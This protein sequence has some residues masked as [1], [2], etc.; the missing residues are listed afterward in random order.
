MGLDIGYFFA[1][2]YVLFGL[3]LLHRDF[4]FLVRVPPSFPLFCFSVLPLSLASVV[5]D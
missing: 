5:V 1:L 3:L 2:K 4:I